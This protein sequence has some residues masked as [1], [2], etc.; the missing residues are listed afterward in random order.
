MAAA[1]AFLDFL[2]SAARLLLLL[3]LDDDGIGDAVPA[4][5]ARGRGYAN[6]TLGTVGALGRTRRTDTTHALPGELQ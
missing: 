5:R 4:G 6:A 3:H 1:S 2:P